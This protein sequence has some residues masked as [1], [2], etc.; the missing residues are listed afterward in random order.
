MDKRLS[1]IRSIFIILMAFA[2]CLSYENDFMF[3]KT[4]Q[5]LSLF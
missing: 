2:M 3:C 4:D 1:K 5:E